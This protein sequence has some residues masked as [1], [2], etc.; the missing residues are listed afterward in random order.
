MDVFARVPPETL[1]HCKDS[2]PFGTSLHLSHQSVRDM[3]SIAEAVPKDIDPYKT[4]NLTSTAS[5]GEI[6]T[7]YKKLALRHH[8][9]TTTF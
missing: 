4:L 2:I 3:E 6:K 9:G 7:A 5:A 1:C 8:P